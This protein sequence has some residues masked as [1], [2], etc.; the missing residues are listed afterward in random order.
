MWQIII[1]TRS[2]QNVVMSSLTAA[3]IGLH[4]KINK[5]NTHMNKLAR[6][7]LGWVTVTGSNRGAGGQLSRSQLRH[8]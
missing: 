1:L 7:I 3:T 6:L 8:R 4:L 5:A 2:S